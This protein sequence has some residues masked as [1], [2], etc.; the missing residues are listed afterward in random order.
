MRRRRISVGWLGLALWAMVG[1]DAGRKSGGGRLEA[2]WSGAGEQGKAELPAQAVWCPRLGLL[3]VTAVA[4]DTGVAI[5]LYVPDQPVPGP[6]PV[7]GNVPPAGAGPTAAVAARWFSEA[8]VHGFQGD[9]GLVTMQA[10]DGG[11]V[12][13]FTLRMREIGGEATLDLRG[14]FAVPSIDTTAAACPADSLRPVRDS[15]G[16]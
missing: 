11:W 4:G 10:K 9:S 12:G 14:T 16:R 6:Y 13:R 3:E 8:A 1:C 5:G 15:G 7:A 2:N